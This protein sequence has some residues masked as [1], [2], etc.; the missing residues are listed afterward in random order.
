MQTV[1][2]ENRDSL[3]LCSELLVCVELQPWPCWWLVMRCS[4]WV[5]FTPDRNHH[6]AQ[7]SARLLCPTLSTGASDTHSGDQVWSQHFVILL[8]SMSI[9]PSVFP[10]G[11]PR[12]SPAGTM[13][14]GHTELS[15]SLQLTAGAEGFVGHNHH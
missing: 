13:D 3:A 2:R 10:P 11:I 1:N 5:F 12:S 15:L 4:V 14:E 6:P 8:L 7:G 9:F